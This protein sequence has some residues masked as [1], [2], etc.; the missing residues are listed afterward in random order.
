MIE[1]TLFEMFVIFS[2]HELSLFCNGYTEILC[3]AICCIT[4]NL[5]INGKW[6]CLP[7]YSKMYTFISI[8]IHVIS[9]VTTTSPTS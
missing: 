4:I 3:T 9:R 8:Q 1:C 5:I 2:D 6:R 7:S